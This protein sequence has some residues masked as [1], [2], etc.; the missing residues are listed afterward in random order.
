MTFLSQMQIDHGGFESGVA[1]VELDESEVNAG[2]E[3]MGGVRMPEGMD[4]QAGFG[5]PGT[6]FGFAE[7]PLNAVSAHGFS[8]ARALL[9]IASGGRKEPG[10]VAVRFPVGPQEHEGILG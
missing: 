10:R 4:G 2:F 6:A 5:N 7:G 1:E 3:Q 9:L 8:G